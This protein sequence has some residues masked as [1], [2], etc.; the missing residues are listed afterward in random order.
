MERQLTITS[1]S[2]EQLWGKIK[3]DPTSSKAVV[4]LV[5]GIGEHIQRYEHVAEDFSKRGF[6]LMGFDQQGHGKSTGKRGVIAPD[7]SLLRDIEKAVR[8]A[9][10]LAPGKPVYLYGHSLGGMEVLFYGIK[11]KE[12]V[13][14][15]IASAPILDQS[16][17]SNKQKFLVKILKPTLPKLT[18]NS[19]LNLAALSRDAQVITNY[20]ED[21]LVHNKGNAELGGFIL[22]GV[23]YVLNHAE[24]WHLPLYLAH[25]SADEICPVECSRQFARMHG[26]RV[27]YREW[28]GLFHEIHNEPEKDEV[29]SAMLDWLDRQL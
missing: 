5:H 10:E 23:D 17:V 21:P 22:D 4:V 11:S 14:G 20:Q 8:L 6:T 18:V 13:N 26:D 2:G 1:V 9:K 16:K 12:A 24:E 29:I 3:Q 25:G 27:T 15:I 28:E 19:E 7:N